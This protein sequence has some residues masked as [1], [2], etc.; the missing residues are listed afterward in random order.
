MVKNLEQAIQKAG[1][2]VKLLWES[3]TQPADRAARRAGI[4]ELARRADGVAP[5]RGPVRPVAPHGRPEHQGPRCAEAD[6]QARR[7][8]RCEIPR[9]HGQAVRRRQLRRLRHRRQH[10]LPPRG[11]R[12][13]GRRHSAVDQLAALSRR[14]GRLRRARLAR[15][16]LVLSEGRSG[17]VPLP[18]PGSRRHE[19]HPRGDGS[20]AA[21]AAL[22]PHDALEDRRQA[23]SR[24]AP[25]HGR[26]ARLGDVG[27]VGGQRRRSCG[28][29]RGRRRSTA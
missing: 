12:V 25:R 28:A 19:R 18:G 15:R 11:G 23:G 27:A 9:R 22:L 7:Q 1:S 13:P 8:Q 26:R 14:D 24:V 3:K 21:E 5:H 20:G 4:H 29:A 10:P 17:S 2:P 6:Q 16:Q